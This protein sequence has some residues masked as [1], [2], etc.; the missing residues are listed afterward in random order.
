[1][2]LK[3]TENNKEL[4]EINGQ[5]KKIDSKLQIKVRNSPRQRV[6]GKKE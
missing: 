6:G 5:A 3:L 4:L 1:M 2:P